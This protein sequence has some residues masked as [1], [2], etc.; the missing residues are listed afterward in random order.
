MQR[1]R[2]KNDYREPAKVRLFLNRLH[3]AKFYGEVTR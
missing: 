3:A 2:T 1:T